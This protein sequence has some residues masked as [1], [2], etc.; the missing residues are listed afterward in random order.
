MDNKTRF[1]QIYVKGFQIIKI[2]NIAESGKF[3]ILTKD[4][5]CCKN[6]NTKN[7]KIACSTGRLSQNQYLLKLNFPLFRC[8]LRI[9]CIL[10][11]KLAGI[12]EVEKCLPN[13]MSF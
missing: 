4:M 6:E 11:K 8:F 2:F 3:V 9:L 5:S 1:L 7:G 12:C 10:R 13:K